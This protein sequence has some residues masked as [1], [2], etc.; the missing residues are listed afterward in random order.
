MIVNKNKPYV[1]GV[2]HRITINDLCGKPG[3]K[4][5]QQ[6]NSDGS[7]LLIPINNIDTQDINQEVEE[8]R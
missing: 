1:I 8:I 3:E 4:F 7:I 6:L 2:D 5:Y